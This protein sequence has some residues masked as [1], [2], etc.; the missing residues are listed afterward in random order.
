MVC[1]PAASAFLLTVCEPFE[2]AVAAERFREPGEQWPGGWV[3]FPSDWGNAPEERLLSREVLGQ[4]QS[5][6]DGLLPSQREVV[7]LRDVQGWTAAE[8]CVGTAGVRVESTGALAP[9]TVQGA[10]G[11]GGVPGSVANS[12]AATSGA[13]HSERGYATALAATAISVEGRGLPAVAGSG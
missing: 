3:S 8:V 13:R 2:A 9:W 6:I 4:I 7:L 11:A 12:A 5:A 10:S 1:W